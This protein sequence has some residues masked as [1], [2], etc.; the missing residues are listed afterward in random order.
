MEEWLK[1]NHVGIRKKVA[2]LKLPLPHGYE[3]EDMLQDVLEQ[4]LIEFSRT[5]VVPSV[6]TFDLKNKA[7]YALRKH[8]DPSTVGLSGFNPSRAIQYQ[9]A[10]LQGVSHEIACKA[11]KDSEFCF[12]AYA[13]KTRCQAESAADKK[14]L[15]DREIVL[16]DYL[17]KI[18]KTFSELDV[19]HG[20]AFLD[21]VKSDETPS[22]YATRNGLSVTRVKRKVSQV[23]RFLRRSFPGIL[24]YLKQ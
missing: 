3:F 17:K 22:E 10:H 21:F 13:P 14:V 12:N 15:S 6:T 8:V 1:K 2:N 20:K 11:S 7:I 9:K 16:R 24:D 4:Y 19:L 23:R 5:S 18:D